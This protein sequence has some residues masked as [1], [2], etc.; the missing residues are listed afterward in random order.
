MT[1]L[2]VMQ[3]RHL[4]APRQRTRWCG[5]AARAARQAAGL[6]QSDVAEALDVHRA[7]VLE[8]E[9]GRAPVLTSAADF[10][11]LCGVPLDSL[12]CGDRG[13]ETEASPAGDPTG[14]DIGPAAGTVGP[15]RTR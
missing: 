10:A 11:A 12:L 6:R 1:Y 8:W 5:S 9:A 15:G 2:L 7:T 13:H 3:S 14:D 4:N